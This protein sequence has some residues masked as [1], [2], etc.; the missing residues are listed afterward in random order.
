MGV[1]LLQAV[2]TKTQ[3]NGKKKVEKRTG[4]HEVKAKKGS[5]G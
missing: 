3:G 4:L 2:K 5:S 1:I